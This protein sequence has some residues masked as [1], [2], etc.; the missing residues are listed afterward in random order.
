[1]K[2]DAVD[3]VMD[4][5][6]ELR[7]D[8]DTSPMAPIG[9]IHRAFHLLQ[10]QVRAFMNGRGLEDWEFDVLATLRRAGAPYTLT[11]KQLVASSMVSSSALTNRVDQLVRRGLVT[12]EVDPNNRRSVLVTLAPE[13]L[14]LVDG[15]VADHVANERRLLGA[16]TPSE[17]DELNRLLRK[18]L[19]SLGDVPAP[20]G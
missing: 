19:V 6:A 14:A 9:R 17:V 12:R 5:W 20:R 4:Q 7:P 2:A 18:V 15:L 3:G 8:V 11:P 1:M 13:G 10:A 16:L